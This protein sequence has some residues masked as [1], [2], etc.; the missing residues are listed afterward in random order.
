MNKKQRKLNQANTQPK[1]LPKRSSFGLNGAVLKWIAVLSMLIDHSKNTLFEA[2]LIPANLAA[3]SPQILT[4]G[5]LILYH[6]LTWAGR[7]AFPIFCF[8]LVEGFLHT[9]DRKKYLLRLLLFGFIS[10]LPYDYVIHGGF[11]W[12]YQNVFFT[13]F[14][15][16]LG[17]CGIDKFRKNLPSRLAVAVGVIALAE[18]F[19][20]DYGWTGIAV[21]LLFALLRDREIPRDLTAG[22]CILGAGINEAVSWLDFIL[23]HFYDGE[24][25]RQCKYFFYA[26]YPTHLAILWLIRYLLL[27]DKAVLKTISVSL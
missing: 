15:G 22:L 20:T 4:R 6:S 3:G 26:F 9:R 19:R 24:R 16:L 10:E 17:L 23:F 5:D 13:L 8:L 27:Y 25:G 2:W 14:L 1:P 18:L 11:N 21:I 7:L 12:A